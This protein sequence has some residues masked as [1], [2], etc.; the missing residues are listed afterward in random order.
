M[1]Y[2][3]KRKRL[4]VKFLIKQNESNINIYTF[5]LSPPMMDEIFLF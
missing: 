4:Y 2:N 1:I 3:Y 5:T